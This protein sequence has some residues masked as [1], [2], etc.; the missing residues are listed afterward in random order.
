MATKNE[1][2]GVELI[3]PIDE[4]MSA[5]AY[6]DEA[7]TQK[8]IGEVKKLLDEKTANIDV[9]TN[10]G[11]KELKSYAYRVSQTISV[12][13]KIANDFTVDWRSNI[14]QVNSARDS[15][16]S[17]LEP[18]RDN[19][20]KPV[21]DWEEA[22]EARKEKFTDLTAR[23]KEL[24]EPPMGT[25]LEDLKA[26]LTELEGIAVGPDWE[27][28]LPVGSA[29]KRSS[30]SA[31]NRLIVLAEQAEEQE[32]E[33]Q[34]LRDEKARRDEADAKAAAEK[35]AEEQRLADEKAAEEKRLAD[36]KA[37]EEKRLADEKAAE[38]RTKRAA[39]EAAQKARDEEA[40]KAQQE[41]DAA[42]ERAAAA[43]RKAEE[44]KREAQEKAD[45]EKAE[46][47][48][49]A[50]AEEARK[51][52]EAHRARINEEITEALMMEVGLDASES[53]N[54]IDAIAGRYTIPHL[55]INY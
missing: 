29:N 26:N 51:A 8:F 40:A 18:I 48:S 17:Q 55:T 16:I 46:A 44:E 24:G 34:V 35:E 32:R 52:D 41:I 30:I 2:T 49:A 9:T 4:F 27:E 54:L 39:E 25:S 22:Q 1:E 45:R 13:K 43:E 20:R 14:K 10:A 31:L 15:L 12:L 53:E 33:L 47:D 11:R 6:M 28:Y 36:E 38:E 21:T 3:V 5:E 37:A 7:K 23:L 19:T 50:E 42:N